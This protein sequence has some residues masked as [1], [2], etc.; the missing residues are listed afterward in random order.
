VEAERFDDGRLVDLNWTVGLLTT[1]LLQIIAA[2]IWRTPIGKQKGSERIVYKP[3]SDKSESH[4]SH[5]MNAAFIRG[6][7]VVKAHISTQLS[8]KIRFLPSHLTHFI[9]LQF[10]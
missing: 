8:P 3:E 2:A 7:T 1:V 4:K 5:Q 10:K 6:K 9:S